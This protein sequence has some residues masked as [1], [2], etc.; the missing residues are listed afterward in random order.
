M[1][2]EGDR[3]TPEKKPSRAAVFAA[4][5]LRL[6][7][8]L[9]MLIAIGL[10]LALPFVL[11]IGSVVFLPLVAALIVTIILSPLA[12]KLAAWLPNVLASLVALLVFFAILALAL[13][14]VFAPAVTLYDQVPAMVA[15]VGD[16]F[17]ELQATFAWVGQMNDQLNSVLGSE[18]DNQV[19]LAGPT[20]LQQLAFATP[21]VL[22]EL[23]LT[24]ML[25][26]FMIEA[27]VR[28]RR[29][30]TLERQQ[31]GASLKAARAIREVQDRVAAY[32]LTVGLINLCVGVVVGLGAWMLGLDA[33][34]MWGGLA[35]LLN[36]VPYI[37]PLAMVILLG[38]F[39]LGSADSVF[40]GLIPAAA[41]L[42]LHT[43]EANVITPSVLGARFTMNPVLILL[44]LSY[45]GWIWG[46]P[47]AL[48]SVPILLTLT[49]LADHLGRPNFIGF[50]FGEPLFASN[51]LEMQ[52]ED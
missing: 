20:V 6:I 11:S 25:A 16:H 36:F 5:E 44:A 3:A 8:A 21:T 38:L 49:A 27:R 52:A 42:A 23:L 51:V 43:V 14:A 1:S 48:L 45:F 24:F 9:V 2:A 37:G 32:I 4:Q 35:A 26:F 18:D 30:L 13:T 33:P 29:R 28:L 40:V 7:S 50:L 19:V 41:Y 17:S 12:D 22:L 46:V 31:V 34:I 47:G 39:G 15:Q 10:F